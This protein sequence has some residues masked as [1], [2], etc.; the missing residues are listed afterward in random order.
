LSATSDIAAEFS[1]TEIE[2]SELETKSFALAEAFVALR[3]TYSIDHVTEGKAY[4]ARNNEIINK[5]GVAKFLGKMTNHLSYGARKMWRSFDACMAAYS[6][7][8]AVCQLHSVGPTPAMVLT[9]IFEL[10]HEA[11][12]L[13]DAAMVAEGRR[14]FD[15][16][17]DVR[18]RGQMSLFFKI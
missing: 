8:E 6:D 1:L 13:S 11:K 12:K 17:K 5:T 16:L 4:A 15:S 2:A 7:F 3:S 9:R 18:N 14:L 10:A